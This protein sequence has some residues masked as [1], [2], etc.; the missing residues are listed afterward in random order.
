MI[1]ILLLSH[2]YPPLLTANSIQ[3]GRWTGE[4]S[5]SG[6][7]IIN[8]VSVS[9]ECTTEKIGI[10]ERIPHPGL[11][12][13]HTFSLERFFLESKIKALINKIRPSALAEPD[14]QSLWIPFASAEIS[15]LTARENFDL[16][17]SCSHYITNHLIALKVWKKTGLPWIACFSDPWTESIYF[18]EIDMK[19]GR[20]CRDMERKIMEHAARVVV[21]CREMGSLFSKRY[22]EMLHSKL[23]H[24]PHC[25]DRKLTEGIEPYTIKSEGE[26]RGG[27]RV[28]HTG[29]FYGK[30][31]PLP[32][33]DALA[34]LRKDG[35]AGNIRCLFVGAD[36]GVYLK[37]LRERDLLNC[38][39]IIDRVSY[40]ESI[41]YMKGAQLL[42][43]ID[44][45]CRGDESVFFPSKLADYLGT[46]LPI[47]GLTPKES[48]SERILSAS[49]HYV[50]DI[51]DREETI[52]KFESIFANVDR[53]S[54]YTPPEEY[55]LENVAAQWLALITETANHP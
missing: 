48:C 6:N 32:F 55:S 4:V 8:V 47:A 44:A 7:I 39:D 11:L 23:H 17:I 38:I 51:N 35:N 53:K 18:E 24:I 15:K 52:K 2:S 36:R 42:L 27:I 21:P 9:P 30:R 19:H 5:K 12:V 45:P 40:E 28:I 26:K 10:R 22:G 54:Y 25:Y 34:T 46:G 3:V 20:W 31:T 33:L 43:L 49:G 37:A 1:K 41:A 14:F 50:I 29:S 16:I 13:Q